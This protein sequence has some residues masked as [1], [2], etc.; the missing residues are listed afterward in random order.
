LAGGFL[1][2]T[3]VLTEY[4]EEALKKQEFVDAYGTIFEEIEVE[5]NVWSKKYYAVFL[6]KR[7]F[8]SAILIGLYD[9]PMVQYALTL[10]VCIIPVRCHACT[11]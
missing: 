7:L 5:E 8:Y 1:A 10:A 9:F 2:F 6:I 3:T 11:L 4:D